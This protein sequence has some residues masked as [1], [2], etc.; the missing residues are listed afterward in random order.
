MY[1][2][3]FPFQ[4]KST[5]PFCS[6]NVPGIS[7]FCQRYTVGYCFYA[8]A[9]AGYPKEISG[10]SGQGSCQLSSPLGLGLGHREAKG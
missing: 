1:Q 4:I 8:Q 10:P 7:I 9:M 6:R 5:T 2:L 3:H